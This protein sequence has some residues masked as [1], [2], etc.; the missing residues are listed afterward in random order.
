MPNLKTVS[1][2]M[3]IVFVVS[4]MLL[5]FGSLPSARFTEQLASV[6]LI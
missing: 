6:G 1:P 5:S 3:D 2:G 4:G